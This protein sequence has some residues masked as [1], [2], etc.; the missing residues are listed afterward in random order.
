[1]AVGLSGVALAQET[2]GTIAG[3][4]TDQQGAVL[5]GVTVVA[6]HVPTGRAFQF[7]STTTGA[8]RAT[9]LPSGAYTLTFTLSG[10]QTLTVS[11][12]TLSVNDRL[13]LN[14]K[15]TVGGV[16]EAVQV[17]ADQ[18]MVQATSAVQQLVSSKQVQELP[19]NNRNFVQLATL[20]PGVSSDLSDEVGVG[21][22]STVSISVNGA[23]RNALN[24][25][26]RR[27]RLEH[28]TV[29]D[30]DARVD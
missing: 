16:T 26:E 14:G 18:T 3:I 8:Y 6:T 23:R 24:C 20:A 13:E 7:V 15:L 17:T 30:A 2:T 21:L 10:F 25:L 27:R 19:L 9:L 29:V 28:H 1:L 5:P 12:I 22:T 11:G 4:V